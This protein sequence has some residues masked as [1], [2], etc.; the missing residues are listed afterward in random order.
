M[1]TNQY[2]DIVIQKIPL[3]DVRAPIEYEKGKLEGALNQPIMTDEE[4]HLVGICYKNKGSEAANA[5]GHELV[6]GSVKDERVHG[7]VKFF[8]SNPNGLLYCYR[9]GQRSQIA[10]QWIKEASGLTVPR[11]E[12]GFKAFRNYLLQA[13]E[14]NAQL[15]KPLV[16][17]GYTGAGKTTVLKQLPQA[18]DLEG[19][20]NHRGS[21]FGGFIT[22]QPTQIDFEH[23]LAGALIRHK[24]RGYK[25]LV[26][27]NEGFRIGRSVIYKPL[28]ELLN[29][30]SLIIVDLPFE[31]R[32][33]A[34]TDEYVVEAQGL[35]RAQYGEEEGFNRWATSIREALSRIVKR[36]G[37]ERYQTI[38]ACFEVAC[39]NQLSTGEFE[40]HQEWVALLLRDYYD[41]MY[42]YQLHRDRDRIEFRGTQSEVLAYFKSLE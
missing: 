18:I 2:Q 40:N 4:R 12:G 30:G 3:L 35:Y 25:T 10:Q 13:L 27:E 11:I 8:S 26:I 28:G 15:Y 9:G 33:R 41:P 36:L 17:G 20:A 32:A 23:G 34:I 16:L 22:P 19:L 21:A 42:A 24:H 31:E 29:S 37:L 6:S 39:Q 7:W 14:P 38:A 1:T 5:L